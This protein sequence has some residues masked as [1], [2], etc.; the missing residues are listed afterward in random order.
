MTIIFRNKYKIDAIKLIVIQRCSFLLDIKFKMWN[1][2]SFDQKFQI[3]NHSLYCAGKS[4]SKKFLL[5]TTTPTPTHTLYFSDF[6][7]KN[8]NL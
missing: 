1:H 7:L 5:E 4:F 8:I 6:N 2:I 3:D